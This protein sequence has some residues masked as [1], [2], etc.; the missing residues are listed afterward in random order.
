M[1]LTAIVI[2]VATNEIMEGT[3]QGILYADDFVL[4]AKTMAELHRK[5]YFEK[6]HLK[7][8]ARK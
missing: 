5:F 3:L 7:V 4:I 1:L 8:N 2:N 6:I